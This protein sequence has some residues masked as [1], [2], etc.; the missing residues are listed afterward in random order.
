MK[1][2]TQWLGS[3][4][5]LCLLSQAFAAPHERFMRGLDAF[6][7]S[8]E[9]TVRD[10]SGRIL[11]T[12]TGTV[13]LSKPNLFRWHYEAP[14]EQIIVADGRKVW[15]FEPD[16]EQVTVRDQSEAQAQSPLALL[17]DP[18]ALTETYDIEIQPSDGAIEI[19][20]LL[21]KVGEGELEFVELGFEQGVLMSL[22]IKDGFGQ[23]TE[24][25]FSEQ[26]RN[27]KLAPELFRFVPPAGVDVVGEQD[28]T[29]PFAIPDQ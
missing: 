4:A 29:Q 2:I 26:C 21:P 1:A 17:T 22:T 6:D 20:R 5:S 7:A 28:L 27:K 24:V 25:L 23:Q 14:Y 3:I 19:S 15:I 18:E 10:E 13:A 16:L 8:F 12:T 11:E 9:Q